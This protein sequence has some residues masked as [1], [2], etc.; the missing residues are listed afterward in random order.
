MRSRERMLAACRGQAVD[1]P[2]LWL[3][4]QAG[5][6]LP[7]YRAVRADH[8]FW[9]VVR[10]PELVEKVTLQPLARFEL[11]AAILFCDILVVLDVLGAEVTYAPGGPRVSPALRDQAGLDAL[12]PVDAEAAFGYVD[13]AIR[14][15]CARLQPETA[16]IGFA[17]APWTLAAYLV[18]GGPSRDSAQL[19]AL[20]YQQPRVFESM[21]ER[22]AD[23]V[24]ELLLIQLRAGAD[25]VQ[26][27]DTWAGHLSPGDY[28][29]LALPY[30]R[31]IIERVK[32]HGAPVIL[33]LR[34]AAGHLDAAASS[35]CDVL[36]VDTS[37]DLA[38]ARQRLDQSIALQG[39]LE[40]ALLHAP[41]ARLRAEVERMARA[42]EG[43]GYIVN[44][45][46]GLVPSSPIDGVA[47]LVDA[48][49][50]L[51]SES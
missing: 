32:S 16:V 7:E 40:P 46:Q 10:T 26:I 49:R 30:T 20:A 5:R 22:I 50:A 43:G 28:T 24:A 13:Q 36:S 9:E 34:N 48:V 18:E 15:L 44:L 19:K 51:G 33:Y 11:D 31:R 17:G 38:E 8:S 41:E 42:A 23:V 3:M 45:G 2:P 35:G 1:R 27:F 47:R 4:R 25:L 14:R 12:L 6:Y 37:I 29:S 21:M 39:N